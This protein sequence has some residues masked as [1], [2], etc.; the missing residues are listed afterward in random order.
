MCKV[1]GESIDHLFLHC[2]VAKELWDTVLS[3]FGVLWV[4]PQHLRELIEGW[5]TGLPRQ[6]IQDMVCYTSLPHVVFME[7]A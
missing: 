2:P 3:L 6:A 5:F 4:M 7:G 1:D